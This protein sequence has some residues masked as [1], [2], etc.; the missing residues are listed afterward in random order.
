MARE[1]CKIQPKRG[2]IMHAVGK[3]SLQLGVIKLPTRLWLGLELRLGTWFG[4]GLGLHHAVSK[5]SL[6]LGV[7]NHPRVIGRQAPLDPFC[8]HNVRYTCAAI[9]ILGPSSFSSHSFRPTC[10]GAYENSVR[11]RV[12]GRVMACGGACKN[13]QCTLKGNVSNQLKLVAV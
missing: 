7:I 9:K 10:G 13:E 8:V 1:N 11:V 6:Q 5:V 4:L 12:R 2:T 3:V